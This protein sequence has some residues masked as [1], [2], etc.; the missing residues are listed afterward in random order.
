MVRRAQAPASSPAVDDWIGVVLAPADT[1]GMPSG[2]LVEFDQ[3][4]AATAVALCLKRRAPV[5][6]HPAA[7][8]STGLAGALGAILAATARRAHADVPLRV[9][10]AGPA[11]ALEA[12]MTR[13]HAALVTATATVLLANE[14]FLAR[15]VAPVRAF[16]GAP[17]PE[18]NAAELAA[19]LGPIVL[20]LPIV[21]CATRATVADVAS[22]RRGDVWLPG[23][24]PLRLGASRELV[25]PVF[26]AAPAAGLGVRAE[27]GVDGHLVLGGEP[28]AICAPEAE[29]GELGPRSELLEAVGEVPVVVRVEIGEARMQAREWAALRRGD[30]VALGRRVGEPVILR[31]GGVPV[32]RGD[33]VEIDG[34]VGVRIVERVAEGV[35]P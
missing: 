26:L 13:S 6:L 5:V 31:V 3:A 20:E 33:L 18:S 11:R 29:M 10:A 1:P 4:L 2:F 35:A 32:A 27:L 28:G 7:T 30:V 21:A 9:V 12:D 22:L 8:P 25:G 16:D 14:A 19:A 23:V 34:E 17:T 15:L 24:W